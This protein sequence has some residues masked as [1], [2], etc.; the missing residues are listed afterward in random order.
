MKRVLLA[1]ALVGL[2]AFVSG[3]AFA[4]AFLSTASPA[5]GATVSRSPKQIRLTFTEG[6]E[7]AFSSVAISGPGGAGNFGKPQIAGKEMVIPVKGALPAGAY[8]VVWHATAVDTHKTQ[9]AFTF[10]VKP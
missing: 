3:Q 6:L 1:S 5:V 7:P 10:S 4:H 8:H 9:G 2:G